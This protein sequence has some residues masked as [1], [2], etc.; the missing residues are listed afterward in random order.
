DQK[1]GSDRDIG[2]WQDDWD[3]AI[4]QE[5]IEEPSDVLTGRYCADRSSYQIVEDQGRDGELSG[6]FAKGL[7]YDTVHASSNEHSRRLDVDCPDPICEDH[8]EHDKPGS[9][10]T[11]RFLRNPEC[12]VRA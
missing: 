3:A 5:C 12:I 6:C 1:S 4:A 8:D 9:R 10:C 7:V 11:N 2:H